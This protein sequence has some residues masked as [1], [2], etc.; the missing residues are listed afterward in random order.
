MSGQT[1]HRFNIHTGD[2]I[3]AISNSLN[4]VAATLH[5]ATS[6]STLA[7]E[8]VVAE[9]NKLNT[10][11]ASITDGV[12]VLDLHRNIVL[13]NK[14]AEKISGFAAQE[15][16]GQLADNFLLFK[17][18]EGKAV[19]VAEAFKTGQGQTT[20]TPL[21]LTLIGK[22]KQ[23]K[24]IELIVAPV[25]EGVQ[26]DLGCVLILYDISQRKALEQMQIDFVSMASHEIRTP[27]T[28][29]VNYL[30]TVSDE[31]GGKLDPE[32]KGFLDRALQSAKQ[33]SVLVT[34]LLSVSKVE[35][36]SFSVLLQP[37]NWQQKLTQLVE[38]NRATAVQKGLT[39]TLSLP[40]QPLPQVMADEV[41]I[42]EVVNNLIS[43]AINYS[44][45][46]GSI[47]VSAKIEGNEVITAIADN[48]QG[49]PKE[50]I[51][52]LF[53]KFFRVAGSLEQMRQGTGLGLYISKSIVQLHHGRIWVES[54]L[55]KGST[56]YFSLPIPDASG[57]TFT[58]A[59]LLKK[60]SSPA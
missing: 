4:T 18:K 31:A 51:P 10:I 44:K 22:D 35:R 39:L 23:E 42:S 33:L 19:T 17:N 21:S 49:I 47:E 54:E 29:I 41:R 25:A 5:Q 15:I 6:Q 2:E 40:P 56:F 27:L 58:M 32:L 50:A 59:D 30:Q 48:G 7:K 36:G 11:I 28:S 37:L 16:T 24:Q 3:E 8:N 12:V 57:N 60:P 46:S 14:A 13:A 1:E 20:P 34:N 55:G 38:D 45:P 52:N 53:A 43:N 9:R 26:A